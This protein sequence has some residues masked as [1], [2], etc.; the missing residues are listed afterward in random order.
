[1]MTKSKSIDR[2]DRV[3]ADVI[4][5]DVWL[6][7]RFPLSLRMVEDLLAARVDVRDWLSDDAIAGWRAACRTTLGGQRRFSNLA[8]ETTLILGAVMRLPLRRT[9]GFVRSLM[10]IM[11]LD[12]AV[13]DHTKLARR[14]RT[15]DIREQC[16]KRKGPIDIVI[17][18]TGLK[19]FGAGESARAKHGQ[20]RRSWRKLHLSVDPASHEIVAHALT[21][22]DKADAS[23][24]GDLVA[25][26]GGNIGRMIADGAYDG[27][28][29]Y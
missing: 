8:I 14:R 15:A 22:D 12:L 23:M 2:G 17:D 20:S 24:A 6:S 11:M 1:M 27:A 5:Q 26:S 25:N 28:P 13:P 7:I 21:D 9:E 29:I 4:E 3:P 10:Q 19:F 18:S 16:W